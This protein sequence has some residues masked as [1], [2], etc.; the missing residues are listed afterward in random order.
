MRPS[1]RGGER[2]RRVGE[3]LRRVGERLR[4][5]GVVLR[6]RLLRI[7][8]RLLVRPWVPFRGGDLLR[9]RG[10]SMYLYVGMAPLSVV[11]CS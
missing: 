4:R 11:E 9:L 1:V 2:L 5:V 6:V 8:E 7:G 3:R 10:R